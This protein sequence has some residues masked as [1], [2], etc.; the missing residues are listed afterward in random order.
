LGRGHQYVY[1]ERDASCSESSVDP[2]LGK[3]SAC[4]EIH[5][6]PRDHALLPYRVYSVNN[7]VFDIFV[8]IFF[9]MLGY[10]A[11]KLDFEPAPFILAVVLGPMFEENLRQSLIYSRGD[12]S[13]F[14]T[15][16]ISLL[17]MLVAILLVIYPFIPG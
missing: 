11:K 4:P 2:R 7:N 1:W 3:D 17:F 16:P 13:I 8:M 10:L 9:G 12:F 14:F 15:R 6:F 5:P